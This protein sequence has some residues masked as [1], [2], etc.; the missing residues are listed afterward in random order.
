V[1]RDEE[2]W[3]RTPKA[4]PP[5]SLLI[6]RQAE[7]AKVG[8]LKTSGSRKKVIQAQRSFAGAVETWN[9][10]KWVQQMRSAQFAPDA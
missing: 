1:K 8:P 3:V 5:E 9:E 4:Q 7:R 10:Q 2:N 6:A